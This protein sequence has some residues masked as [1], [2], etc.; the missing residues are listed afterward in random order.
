MASIKKRGD[1]YLITVSCG[2]NS[3]GKKITRNTT[4]HPELFTAKGNAK[5]EK[6]ILKEVNSFAADFEKKVLTGQYTKGNKMTF[7][8]YSERYLTE[9]AEISQAPQTLDTTRRAIKRFIS[10]F[11]YMTLENL[12]PLFLQE[13]VNS[14]AKTQTADGKS[15]SFGTVK[16]Y[17]A[18][19]SAMLSQATRW[20][21]ISSNPMERVQLKK[22]SQAA[23]NNKVMYFTPE[24]A[25]IFLHILDKSLC[26]EYSA[27]ERKDKAGS[28]YLVQEYQSE[29]DIS[30]QLKLFFYLAMFTGCRRGELIALTWDDI[31]FQ[32]SCV[33]YPSPKGNGLLRA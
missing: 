24:Q 28:T 4:Y 30:M 3:Q 21:L 12:N 8:E 20:N 22:D 1:S 18:V 29:H 5:T 26:Y 32:E 27:R 13:Y 6:A 7:E 10:A 9:C 16:R 17:T 11:G 33:N 19:L 15:L 14:L 25:E 2:Y 31:D 23:G